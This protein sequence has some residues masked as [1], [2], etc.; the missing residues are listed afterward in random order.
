MTMNSM[1]SDC[2]MAGKTTTG[3]CPQN[4]CSQSLP[5]AFAFVTTP[6][7]HHLSALTAPSALPFAIAAAEFHFSVR[8][9]I[10]RRATSPPAY[11]LNQVFRI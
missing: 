7:E 4:C 11:L 3:N 6:I 10:D 9:P 8:L 1:G 5:Q 2:H